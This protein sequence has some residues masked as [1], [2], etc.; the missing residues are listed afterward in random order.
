MGWVGWWVGCW[1]EIEEGGGQDGV[2]TL[3]DAEDIVVE[4][5][6]LH[7]GGGA[8]RGRVVVELHFAKPIDVAAQRVDVLALTLARLGRRL[9]VPYTCTS[10][11]A[12]WA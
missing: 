4:Q 7:G 12:R 10:R 1:S 2:L 6:Q 11:R 9:A 8:E 3:E 5:H